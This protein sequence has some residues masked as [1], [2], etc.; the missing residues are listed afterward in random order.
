MTLTFDSDSVT[1]FGSA[2]I[3]S[4]YQT[5]PQLIRFG[6]VLS[7]QRAGTTSASAARG[8]RRRRRSRPEADTSS[9]RSISHPAE[10][11]ARWPLFSYTFSDYPTDHSRL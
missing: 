4:R 9:D 3:S 5:D 11:T 1:Q 8:S 7:R 2:Q 6:A 10:N